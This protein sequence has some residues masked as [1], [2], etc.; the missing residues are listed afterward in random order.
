[1]SGQRFFKA[2]LVAAALMVAVPAGAQTVSSADVQRLQDDV[3][4][5]SSDISRLRGT[6][7]TAATRLQDELDDLR[8]EVTYLK[9]K[10]RKEGSITRSDYTD[11]RSRLQELRT[12]ARQ[13]AGGSSSSAY[14]PDADRGR[15]RTGTS[16]SAAS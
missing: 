14:P 5:A 15:N 10:L 2:V 7:A 1:M 3:Y 16:S 4:Q 6:D 12:R 11:V 13:D 9:V 8:D